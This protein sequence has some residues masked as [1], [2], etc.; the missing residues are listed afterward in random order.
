M[1]T[2]DMVARAMTVLREEM[3][4]PY[5]TRVRDY[6]S[7][8]SMGEQREQEL[9]ALKAADEKCDRMNLDLVRRALT[10]AFCEKRQASRPGGDA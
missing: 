5:M 6:V 10:A 3:T 2:D 8:G 9:T 1:V 4:M 7:E